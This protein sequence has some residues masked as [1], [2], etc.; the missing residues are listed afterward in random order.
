[1]TNF[2]AVDGTKFAF[3]K[4]IEALKQSGKYDGVFKLYDAVK[5][6]PNISKYLQSDRRIP[7]SE[8]VWRHYPELEE[9]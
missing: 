9:E 7:Y 1:L 5:E 6:R 8:G 3:P 4:S 2:Q